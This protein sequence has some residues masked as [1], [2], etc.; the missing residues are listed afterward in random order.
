M[1]ND[2]DPLHN[3]PP[4]NVAQIRQARGK[5]VCMALTYS[6]GVFNDNF[7]KQA[8]L[9]IAVAAGMTS[10]QGYALV[11]FTLPFLIFA[12]PAGWCADRFPKRWVVISAK[13]MELAAMLC[14][15]AGIA[16]AHWPLICCMLVIM[17]FQAT[18]FS[19]A[20]NGSIPELYP[21]AY[22]TR[23]NAILRMLVTIAIL[24]GVA[25]AGVALDRTG[26]GFGGIER[27]RLLVGATVVGV[28]LLGVCA[29]YGVPRRPAADPRA[30]F[31][32]DGPLRTFR[33]LLGTRRDPLLA[34]TIAADVFI[35]LV[36]SLEILIINPLGLQ[37]FGMSKS[38]TSYLIVSQLVG[39]GIGGIAGSRLV[40]GA[41]WYRA[42][43]PVGV[44]MG[45]VMCGLM[46]VPALPAA[47]Q[48]GALF[49]LIFVVGALAGVMLIPLESFLQVR[50][51]PERKG[52]VLAAVN[53]VV[54]A[55]VLLSG[56]IA[57][58]LNAHAKPTTSFALT[59]IAWILLCVALGIA[60]RRQESRP[61]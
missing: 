52:A 30:S 11:L 57:N 17:G 44:C 13:W 23:A 24:A 54:F 60:Y 34:A 21:A 27:G 33:D 46:A 39:I 43:A 12:A 31:P 55:G 49:A 6:L 56:L 20:L 7:F 47:L 59:G 10:M 19:P 18:L 58:A 5:F 15:A 22:V 4:L 3:D 25:L 48:R 37:Q 29:A 28:A 2:N 38:V 42:I 36:G 35:W 51:A 40:K 45:L 26:T 8:A 14:G 32:W 50:P 41:R 53:F 16:L 1:N 61:C 9:V